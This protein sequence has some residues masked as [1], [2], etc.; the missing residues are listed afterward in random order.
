MSLAFKTLPW[1]PAT[2]RGMSANH[3]S[4]L[5]H[6]PAPGDAS[7]RTLCVAAVQLACEPNA[8][9]RNTA[10]A[11]ALV[12]DAAR[13]GAQLVLLPELMPGGYV[14]TEA[15]WASAEPFEGPSL[16][17]L[18]ALCTRLGLYAGTSFLEACGADF[19]NTFVLVGPDGR[20][21]GRVR[22]NPPASFE[23]YFFRAG[24]DPH[25]FDTPLGR[26]G[27]C[28][29][30]ENALYE[31]YLEWQTAGVDLLLR[32]FSGASFQ[33]KFP[34]RQRDAE[35]LNGTLRDGTAE[36]ARLCGIPVVLANKVGRL[37]TA[38]PGGFPSQDVEFP[39]FSAVADSDGTLLAQLPSGVEGVAVG[40]VHLEPSRKRRT[41]VPRA[42]GRWT[43]KFPWWAFMW[44][45][46][47]RLGERA[48]ARSA[49]RKAAARMAALGRPALDAPAQAD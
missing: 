13:R 35:M 44:I 21:A 30:F 5:I 11:A 48:Y 4:P 38:L 10:R 43:T 29:C 18:R 3:T 2:M 28:I 9:E 49:R 34:V 15:I 16:A 37:R 20:V 8:F 32:P 45:L 22:K 6:A 27:V 7:P 24:D 19:F 17:W 41:P 40:T 33:A 23:A 36:T 26:L 12:E 1:R 39:G 42:H 46:T 31:R 47:Q 25:W 14:L